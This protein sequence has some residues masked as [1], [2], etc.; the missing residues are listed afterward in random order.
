MTSK[1]VDDK[2]EN[3]NTIKLKQKIMASDR[4]FTILLIFNFE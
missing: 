4:S 1:A 2:P 3:K